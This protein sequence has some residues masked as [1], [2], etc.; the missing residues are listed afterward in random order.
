MSQG[1]GHEVETV[2]GAGEELQKFH[3]C[4]PEL[5]AAGALYQQMWLHAQHGPCA[6][7]TIPRAIHLDKSEGWEETL[8]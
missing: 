3:V 8:L 4:F 2:P 1:S 7:G 5:L 6:I